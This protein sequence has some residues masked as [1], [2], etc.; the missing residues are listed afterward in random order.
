M[1]KLTDDFDKKKVLE[2]YLTAILMF[3]EQVFK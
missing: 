1:C 2:K 3:K